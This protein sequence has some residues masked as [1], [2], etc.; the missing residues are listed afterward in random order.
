M[1]P[2]PLNASQNEKFK[3]LMAEQRALEDRIRAVSATLRA[4]DIALEAARSHDQAAKG[5]GRGSKKKWRKS[6]TSSTFQKM[7]VHH[8]TYKL[9][10]PTDAS[11]EVYINSFDQ[12]VANGVLGEEGLYTVLTNS[13]NSLDV[14]ALNIEVQDVRAKENI[15]QDVDLS[16]E[17]LRE[18]LLRAV[19][20][21][22]ISRRPSEGAL[23]LLS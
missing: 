6:G 3:R 11:L 22:K 1:P 8:P 15:P 5:S 10:L 21:E 20:G 17:V 4:G 2:H 9:G 7:E 18:C 23:E 13:I 19:R 14:H 12:L 16:W